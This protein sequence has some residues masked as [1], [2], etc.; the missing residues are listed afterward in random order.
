MEQETITPGRGSIES[1]AWF[2]GRLDKLELGQSELARTMIRHG[3]DRQFDTILRSLRR[4]ASGDARVSGEMRAMLDMLEH[5]QALNRLVELL[6]SGELR[7]W[8]DRGAGKVD[9]TAKSIIRATDEQAHTE[10]QIAALAPHI[11]GED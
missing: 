3:D 11:T 1:A 4:M 10:K 8:E 6:Q 2:R 9:T 7:P 5:N